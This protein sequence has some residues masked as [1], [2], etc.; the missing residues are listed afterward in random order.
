MAVAVDRRLNAFMA[1]MPLNYRQCDIGLDEPG[2]IRMTEVMHPGLL[3]QASL[4]GPDQS[5]CP[6][7]G[8]EIGAPDRSIVTTTTPAR[9]GEHPLAREIEFGQDARS[10]IDSADAA[11]GLGWPQLVT[12]TGHVAPR[13]PD[14]DGALTQI[15]VARP[16]CGSLAPP[17]AGGNQ[18]LHQELS[19]F[20]DSVEQDGELVMG[21]EHHLGGL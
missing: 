6:D 19:W 15:D 17:A 3:G 4:L 7:I 13:S 2:C 12:L 9:I 8:I 11:P 20:G 18:E 10:H 1:E 14:V 16:Q 21:E 5:G